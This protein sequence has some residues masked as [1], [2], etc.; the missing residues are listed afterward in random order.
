MDKT[1]ELVDILS[2]FFKWNKARLTCFTNMLM[3]LFIVRTV[4]LSEIALAMDTR[5]QASSRYKQ[6]QRFFKNFVFDYDE[7]ARWVFWLFGIKGKKVYLAMDRTNWCWGKLSINVFTLSVLCEN[8][9]I[10]IFW[11][12]LP[13]KGNS[14]FE[15][16]RALITRF[17]RI[18]KKNNILGLLADR[19]FGHSDLLRWLRRENI[20]FYI[21]I[22]NGALVKENRQDKNAWAIKRAFS[23]LNNK[24]QNYLTTAMS[25]YNNTLY[26]AAGRSEKGELMIVVTN[27]DPKDAINIYLKRWGIET[28]FSC[29]KG[30]GFHFE[31]THMTNHERIAKLMALLTVGFCWAFRLGQWAV[32]KK[33]VLLKMKKFKDGKR[34]Q[35]S[36]FRLGLDFIR[37]TFIH[38][39][40]LIKQLD[41]LF[42][43]FR[44]PLRNFEDFL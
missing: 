6:I 27:Q 31:D 43:V 12:V 29:L 34:P 24:E 14:S 22:K 10:P 9:A 20:P 33:I 1:S 35:K 3:A 2:K 19:E 41:D 40:K 18:F 13:K 37:E 8:I 44:T 36:L 21:R 15:E 42:H 38:P 5:A 25:I 16:Q 32:T 4:N 7:I 17:I 30:R 23:S 39:R 26:I 11:E 28:L